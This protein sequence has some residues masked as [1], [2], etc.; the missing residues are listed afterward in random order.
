MR[1]HCCCVFTPGSA[2]LSSRIVSPLPPFAPR[3]C[4]GF[5]TAAPG[6]VMA[7]VLP[8][9][10]PAIRRQ[11]PCFPLPGL[12]PRHGWRLDR[13]G[14]LFPLHAM[15]PCSPVWIIRDADIGDPSFPISDCVSTDSSG[16]ASFP[17]CHVLLLLSDD[18]VPKV[19]IGFAR[20]V[21]VFRIAWRVRIVARRH[22]VRVAPFAITS[23]D[24]NLTVAQLPYGLLCR[25][26]RLALRIVNATR[27]LYLRRFDRPSLRMF[28]GVSIWH[29]TL[30]H[31]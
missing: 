4:S 30:L 2:R 25:C 26:F 7:R 29:N 23:L 18:G 13:E 22:R 3:R 14:T 15:F 19:L 12:L 10:P 16:P 6:L 9:M 24:A 11:S 31:R 1:R 21:L 20:A 27:S 5:P 17:S 8:T 28:R